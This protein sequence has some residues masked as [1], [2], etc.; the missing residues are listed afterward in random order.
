MSS[1]QPPTDLYA[2]DKVLP[3]MTREEEFAAF[4]A[5]RTATPE[6]R[7]RIEDR[8]IRSNLGFAAREA[9]KMAGRAPYES[10]RRA[11]VRGLYHAVPRYDETRGHKFISYAVHW[12]RQHMLA[13]LDSHKRWLRFPS[14]TAMYMQQTFRAGLADPELHTLEARMD[15]IGFPEWKR[16]VVRCRAAGPVYLDD[17]DV[18]LPDGD[19]TIGDMIAAP[20]APDDDG[21]CACMDDPA[22]VIRQALERLDHRQRWIIVR[23]FG[24]DNT[25]PLTLEQISTEFGVT[26]ERIRQLKDKALV[27]LRAAMLASDCGDLPLALLTAKLRAATSET[28]LAQ[29]V[30][31]PTQDEEV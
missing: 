4:A 5:R 17:P 13:E 18:T 12:I 11:A 8:I 24:L 1:K 16:E 25:Q 2:A 6:E 28:A 31:T 7:R 27:S 26:R 15:A 23:W 30:V 3:P 21:W 20:E 14:T 22:A 9:L 10:M 29:D 19:R